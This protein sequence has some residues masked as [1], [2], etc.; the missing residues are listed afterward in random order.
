[1]TKLFTSLSIKS[2]TF[3]AYGQ[4][5]VDRILCHELT[6]KHLNQIDDTWNS[7][8]E[9]TYLK[10]DIY[11]LTTLCTIN[12]TSSNIQTQSHSSTASDVQSGSTFNTISTFNI[13]FQLYRSFSL[14]WVRLT[15]FLS[16]E[17]HLKT[18]NNTVHLLWAFL[19]AAVVWANRNPLTAL[20]KSACDSKLGVST[21]Y[22]KWCSFS[23]NPWIIESLSH[24]NELSSWPAK[25]NDWSNLTSIESILFNP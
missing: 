12:S 21:K 23:P 11:K 16:I 13:T 4:T 3:F 20:C 9:N 5:S 24:S 19:V 10:H 1:M 22:C 14:R 7:L 17:D 6:F 25:L 18:L 8:N 15:N 2:W